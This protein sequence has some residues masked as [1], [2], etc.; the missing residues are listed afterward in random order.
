MLTTGETVGLSS[1]SQFGQYIT[2]YIYIYYVSVYTYFLY[3]QISDEYCHL[4]GVIEIYISYFTKHLA[5]LEIFFMG[6]TGTETR[7]IKGD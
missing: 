5:S 1:T 7:P 6:P 2:W 4:E 3:I